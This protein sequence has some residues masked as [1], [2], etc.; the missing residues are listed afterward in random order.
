MKFC[1]RRCPSVLLASQA[2]SARRR[3][4]HEEGDNGD[5]GAA[6]KDAEKDRQLAIKQ[7][8]VQCRHD[9]GDD[10]GPYDAGIQG[11]DP[12]HHGEAT[13]PTS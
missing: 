12:R 4:H 6:L 3:D 10:D 13:F 1:R 8:V 9:A 11:L 5:K 2:G 7:A